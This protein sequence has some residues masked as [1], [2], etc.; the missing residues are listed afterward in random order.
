MERLL[1]KCPCDKIFTESFGLFGYSAFH[2]AC[3][4]NDIK[5]VKFLLKYGNADVSLKTLC[6]LHRNA[7]VIAIEEENESVALLL[8]RSSGKTE[9]LRS[10]LLGTNDKGMTSL[11]IACAQ[12]N[13]K[14]VRAILNLAAKIKLVK[15]VISSVSFSNSTI[16]H[17][18]FQGFDDSM[19]MLVFTS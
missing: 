17:Y 4:L 18:L 12:Q 14:I 1:Q 3:Y 13:V 2:A 16:L 5:L 19:S 9:Q 8:L 10:M 11:M 6:F 15:D 7:L